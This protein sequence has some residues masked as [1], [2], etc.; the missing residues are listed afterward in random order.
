MEEA[1][2]LLFEQRVQIE[3]TK[4]LRPLRI[5][6]SPDAETGHSAVGMDVETYE[7]GR[8]SA[9]QRHKVHGVRL[10]LRPAY[11]LVPSLAIVR[12]LDRDPTWCVSLEMPGV[13]LERVHCS[14]QSE[15]EDGPV[16]PRPASTLGLQPS[17][18]PA[19]SV[20][21]SRFEG[22]E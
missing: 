21:R 8:S 2:S 10:H 17:H 6:S 7:T 16:V 18:M 4:S 5:G 1:V 19:G 3:Q 12:D 9:I 20:G 15:T 11:Y 14:G 22:G 13:D